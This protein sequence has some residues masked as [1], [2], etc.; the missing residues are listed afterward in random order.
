MTDTPMPMPGLMPHIVCDGAADAI[1]FYKQAFGATELI[2]MPGQDGRLMHAAI[3]LNGAVVMMVDENKEFGMLGPRTLG[4]T[5][6]TLHLTVP[7]ADAAIAKAEKAGATVKMPAADMFWG[8][9][10]GVVVDPWG[11]NWS[12]AHPL[13]NRPTGEEELREA[14]RQ[15]MGNQPAG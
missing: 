13:A 14:A 12:I 4:G 2:R 3:Q 7:D 8:D 6:V 15:A 5:P 10:Y 11:H 9:R 1:E